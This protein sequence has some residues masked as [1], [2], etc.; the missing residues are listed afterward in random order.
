MSYRHLFNYPTYKFSECSELKHFSIDGHCQSLET[1]PRFFLRTSAWP[2]LKCFPETSVPKRPYS[3][4]TA[5][6]AGVKSPVEVRHSSSQVK[7]K[8]N[9]K[10]GSEYCW[11][12]VIPFHSTPL[13]SILLHSTPPSLPQFGRRFR[14]SQVIFP[15]FFLALRSLL[16]LLFLLLWPRAMF[17]RGTKC[18]IK[19]AGS[20]PEEGGREG[21]RRNV[22]SSLPLLPMSLPPS[23]V[24][25]Q[26][27]YFPFVKI[28]R[29]ESFSA[30][31]QLNVPFSLLLYHTPFFRIP[32]QMSDSIAEDLPHLLLLIDNAERS[33]AK[34]PLGYRQLFNFYFWNPLRG[35]R[36][37]YVLLLRKGMLHLRRVPDCSSPFSSF[38][39]LL[40]L[41]PLCVT[42]YVVHSGFP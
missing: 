30:P 41:S 1:R 16:L 7:F 6:A 19:S 18:T 23:N 17:K 11:P 27:E 42:T 15:P 4:R 39:L 29:R 26:G 33:A 25:D 28:A 2:Y 40:L 22:P 10:N 32:P 38:L 3:G 12:D 31:P 9:N 5:A 14:S 20:W 21:S 35:G 8:T 37:T 34:P 36:K 24:S 13:H